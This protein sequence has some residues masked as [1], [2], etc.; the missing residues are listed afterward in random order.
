[1]DSRHEEKRS[2]SQAVARAE[3]AFE[4]GRLDGYQ[5][6]EFLHASNGDTD[7]EQPS[8]RAHLSWG[9]AMRR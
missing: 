6:V 2:I 3:A 1:M 5:P 9:P 7:S 4:D 8:D